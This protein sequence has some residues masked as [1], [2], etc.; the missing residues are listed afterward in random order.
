MPLTPWTEQI[1]NHSHYI[2]PTE[3]AGN[4]GGVHRAQTPMQTSCWMPQPCKYIQPQ[5]RAALQTP[6]EGWKTT[7]CFVVVFL[8]KNRGCDILVFAETSVFSYKAFF[9]LAL[10]NS[11]ELIFFLGFFTQ[12]HCCCYTLKIFTKASKRSQGRTLAEREVYRK[13]F[14]P[15]HMG[16]G[17]CLLSLTKETLQQKDQPQSQAR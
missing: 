7:A 14:C 13:Q 8:M 15:S 2:H 9:C 6:S 11:Q 17:S 3:Q 1:P 16:R 10:Q 4:M 5:P 12:C